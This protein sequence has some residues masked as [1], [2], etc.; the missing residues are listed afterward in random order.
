VGIRDRDYIRDRGMWDEADFDQ[1]RPASKG[2]WTRR[3][4]VVLVGVVV[5]FVAL[6][7]P[8]LLNR[9]PDPPAR[10]TP[11]TAPSR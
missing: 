6:L 3:K 4:T 7:V 2:D 5:L 11:P 10:P 8:A 9:P 1:E